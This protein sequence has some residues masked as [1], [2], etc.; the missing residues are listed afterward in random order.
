MKYNV[1][2]V[3]LC[4]VKK[5]EGTTVFLEVEDGFPGSMI[6]SEVAAGR[7]RNLRQYVSPS[8]KV[9]C[10]VLRVT[11][12][13]LELS[14]RRVTGN[15]RLEV[16]DR[17]KKERAFVSM[18]RIVGEK[19]EV[20]EKVKEKYNIV[21][22][23]EEARENVKV[24][25]KFL[26]KEKAKKIFD[27]LK[28]KV[29]KDKEVEREIVLKSFSSEGLK[30]IKEILKLDVEVHYLGSSRFSIFVSGK[31]FK[32][33]NVKMEEVL[34]EIRKRAEKKKAEFSLGKGK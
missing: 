24:L 6:L 23:L 29:G 19:K 10:K 4:R 2:D 22:F 26:S 20:I 30:D 7:I 13:H 16:L 34:E 27:I 1:D 14:L 32:E 9:V 12:D 18:L 8:R 17:V 33:A 11:S 5:I 31:D 28:E 15:E 25:E 21:D 3:V